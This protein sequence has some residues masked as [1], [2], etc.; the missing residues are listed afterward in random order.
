MDPLAVA[1]HVILIRPPGERTH[2]PGALRRSPYPAMTRRGVSPDDRV[3]TSSAAT[4]AEEG[5]EVMAASPAPGV[6]HQVSFRRHSLPPSTVRR[7]ALPDHLA[8]QLGRASVPAATSWS[9][10]TRSAQALE[11]LKLVHPPS[12]LHRTGAARRCPSATIFPRAPQI[13]AAIAT[14]RGAR[15]VLAGGILPRRM[16]TPPAFWPALLSTTTGCPVATEIQ[17][18]V[19]HHRRPSDHR[20]SSRTVLLTGFYFAAS[21]MF[22]PAS[23]IEA[24]S[25]DVKS[26]RMAVRYG[27]PTS[28]SSHEPMKSGV[29]HGHASPPIIG[30]PLL[31]RPG[32]S[33]VARQIDRPGS[34]S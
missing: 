26:V 30:I 10:A 12:R 21:P 3:T 17:R 1:A 18:P 31:S 33:E 4:S 15:A 29:S 23:T 11:K 16:R 22:R 28:C 2:H 5:W 9:Q 25:S 8:A 7:W 19:P 6:L 14:P 32:T 20:R 27:F 34:T 24:T 13:F